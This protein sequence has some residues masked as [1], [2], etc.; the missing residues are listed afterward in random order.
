MIPLREALMLEG[1]GV[2]SLV[3]AGGKTSLMF[4]LAR[5]MADAGEPVLTTTT[6]KI[7]VP[8]RDQSRCLIF[9]ESPE[10]I[11]NKAR[12]LLNDNKLHIT[13]AANQMPGEEKLLGLQPQTIDVL[14]EAKLF[15][16]IIVEA[17]GAARKS[18]KAPADHEPVV[19]KSTS[20]AVGI[21]GLSGVGKPLTEQWVHRAERF[22][23]ITGL[24]PKTPVTEA[25]VGDILVHEKGIF[26]NTPSHAL[27][28]AFLNQADIPGAPEAGK[29][30]ADLLAGKE[31]TGLKRIVIGQT[32]IEPSVLAY[33]DLNS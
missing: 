15:R 23:K 29:T 31:R 6:T 21:C 27:R 4:K 24:A 32:K 7:L 33:F 26:K 10:I 14:F 5:E 17:D 3:G 25:A 30:I 13:A 28:I 16:W 22:A 12:A 20:H 8:A 1:Q 19:P 2:I 9:S 18:L 11:L